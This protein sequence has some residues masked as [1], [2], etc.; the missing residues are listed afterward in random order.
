MAGMSD[1]LARSVSATGEREPEGASKF[2]KQATKGKW[3]AGGASALTL[4]AVLRPILQNWREGPKD[5]FPLSY[6]P[7]FTAKR[8]GSFRVTY[9]IGVDPAGGRHQIPYT[10]AGTGGLNQVRRQINRAVREGRSEAL[11]ELVAASVARQEEATLAYVVRVHLVIGKY[12]LADY[13]AG[14]TRPVSE[15]ILASSEVRRNVA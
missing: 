2:L 15:H 9:L 5:S 1:L 6:Y 14:E 7:M 10:Y 12:R 4:V 3:L 8:S 11:C 13:F